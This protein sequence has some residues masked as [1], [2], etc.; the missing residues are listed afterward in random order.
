MSS[1]G[2][3]QPVA[4]SQVSTRRRRPRTPPKWVWIVLLLLAVLVVVVHS[5]DVVNDHAIA[6][7]ATA[8][9]CFV[10]I[11]VLAVWFL[12]RSGY[13]WLTRLLVAIGC[14]SV[15]GGL[16]V[17]FSI[18]RLTGE[19]V[20]IFVFRFSSEPDRLLK[21]PPDAATGAE[22][23]HVDLRTTT[24]DDFPGF[25]GPHGSEAIDNVK[26]ARHWTQ[27]PPKLMW[28]QKIGAGWSAFSVVNGHAVTMEQR[29]DME[30]TTCYNVETGHLEWAHSVAGKRYQRVEAGVGPRSTPAI[31]D[32]MVFSLGVYGH[33][34]CLDGATG[35]PIWEKDLLKEYGIPEEE[36]ADVVK[37][38][39]SAS[40]L[41]V[42][43]KLIIP[44]GGRKGRL[45][46]L[47]AFDKRRGAVLWEGGQRQISY[48]S[49]NLATLGG[50]EQILIV[51]EDTASGHDVKS[52]KPLWEHPWPGHT[53]RDPNVSQAVAIAPN[54]VLL[55]K[56]Y[57]GGA[58][59]LQ[60]N[61][62]AD[63]AF[64]PH[65]VWQDHHLMKTKF[66]NVT[67]LDGNVYGLSDGILEC[68]E[69]STGAR[70]WKQGHYGHGQILRAGDLLLVLT[71]EGEVVLV[72]AAPDRPNSVLGRFQAIEGLT[73]NNV[74]LYGPYLLVRN[75]EEAAC[76]KLPLDEAQ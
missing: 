52:G 47:A 51:N 24:K 55:S 8:L 10:G 59:L 20:P 14:V 61:P 42:G 49:P 18:A 2:S 33:L 38:G 65:V 12:F 11:I 3:P 7:I 15:V 40:P 16:V 60:L 50:V 56:G 13:H 41:V 64:T 26:L 25:L 27:R 36:E 39:R 9:L 28:R 37:W 5:G 44:I 75:A 73:W 46:T 45:V 67:I 71:E 19:L 35:T 74:A 4:A 23:V 32:G 1:D 76:Y 62:A 70:K 29:G 68:V 22:S 53:N 58:M 30:M 21:V 66:T 54:K 34:A 17:L 48:C 63:G 43:E 72:E 6:N 57:G 69:A 31:D